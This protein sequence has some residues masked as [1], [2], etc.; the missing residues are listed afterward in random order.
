ME[1]K[2]RKFICPVI[3]D[4]RVVDILQKRKTENGEPY[5]HQIT[6]AILSEQAMIEISKPVKGDN[7]LIKGGE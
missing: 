6:N 2:K 3:Y 5:V 1:K 4:K 7:I